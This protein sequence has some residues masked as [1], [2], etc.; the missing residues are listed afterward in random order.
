MHDHAMCT[1][2]ISVQAMYLIVHVMET[3]RAPDMKFEGLGGL[4]NFPQ[5][6]RLNLGRGVTYCVRV[7]HTVSMITFAST[8]NSQP[9][10]RCLHGQAFLW[11]IF[12]QKK[13]IN[14][15]VFIQMVGVTVFAYVNV[16]VE[17]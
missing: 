3:D 15:N 6:Q 17:I 4:N 5:R 2:L 16:S 14:V 1:S 10:S 7:T 9:Q 13:I 8:S 12:I 11:I